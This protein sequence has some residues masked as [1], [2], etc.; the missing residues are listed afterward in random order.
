MRAMLNRPMRWTSPERRVRE[1]EETA[2][3]HLDVL[4]RGALRLTRDRT[5]AGDLVQDA[6]LRAFDRFERFA[7]GT[8]GRAWLFRI[9][10]N[11]F[12]SRARPRREILHDEQAL[13]RAGWPEMDEER[14]L[15]PT[16]EERRLQTTLQEDLQRALRDLPPAF[17]EVVVLVDFEGFRY[18]EA[19]EALGCPLGTVMSRL[20]RGRGLLRLALARWVDDR[21]SFKTGATPEGSPE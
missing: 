21:G 19:A 3:V 8:N 13:S 18:R 5:Q 17:R 4:Y 15:P 16:P 2:L 1:F 20:S 6:L 11:L 12:L 10:R 14:A 9:M 7:P